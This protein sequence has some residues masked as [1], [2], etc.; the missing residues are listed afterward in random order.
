MEDKEWTQSCFT[1]W[2]NYIEHFSRKEITLPLREAAVKSIHHVSRFLFSGLED[3]SSND[4]TYSARIT[5]LTSITQLLQDDDVDV[6]A[7]TADIVSY[8]MQLQ[9]PVHHE[10][11]L[12]LVHKY[13][14]STFSTSNA[15]KS[16]LKT[17]LTNEQSLRE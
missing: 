15:L 3:C 7:D 17:V 8:A 1:I 14:T 4:D 16:A 13:L 10:R 9:T 5:A 2:S 11:A 6:R 12:E